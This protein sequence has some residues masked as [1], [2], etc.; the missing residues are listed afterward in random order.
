MEFFILWIVVA[1]F[2]ALIG[3]RIGRA[4]G[5]LFFKIVFGIIGFVAGSAALWLLFRNGMNF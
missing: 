3:I 2:C 1:G 5:I 4:I